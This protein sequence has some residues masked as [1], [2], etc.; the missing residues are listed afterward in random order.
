MIALAA[1]L[2]V[3][4]FPSSSKTSWMRPE[5]FHLMIGMQR[6]ATV[7]TLAD[8]GWNVKETGHEDQLVIDYGDDKA[9][10]LQFQRDRLRS[11]RFELFVFLPEA[12]T[13]FEEERMFL[14]QSLGAPKKLKSKSVL[15]Y[16]SILPNVMVVLNADPK[17]EN[18]RKGVGILVVRY[19][20]PR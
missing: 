9:V 17:T 11:I 19:Y 13:A 8:R 5:S 2:L 16:D 1:F 4:T 7:K 20:D 12:K 10:T 15:L 3:T 14:H 6:D 18:G